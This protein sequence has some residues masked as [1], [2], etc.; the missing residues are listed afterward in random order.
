MEKKK[1]SKKKTLAGKIEEVTP[2]IASPS[3]RKFV[4]LHTEGQEEIFAESDAEARIQ[5]YELLAMK[6]M[7]K[8]DKK[9]FYEVKG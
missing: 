1:E 8:R 3:L 4:L 9:D 7:C 5:G 2:E 6:G